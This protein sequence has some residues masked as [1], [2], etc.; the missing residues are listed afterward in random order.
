VITAVTT[1]LV[2]ALAGFVPLA[3]LSQ[4]TSIGRLF[5][6]VVVSIGVVVLRRT[7]PDLPRAFRAPLVPW[8]PIASVLACGWL[9]LNLPV[10][11]WVRFLIWMAVGLV[12][13]FVYGPATAG[14]ATPPRRWRRRRSRRS[15]SAVTQP[16]AQPGD[17]PGGRG[18]RSPG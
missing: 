11:T 7:R 16:G 10:E 14:C 6:F 2:A 18:H 15:T 12:L 13:Y 3:E 5:A 4:L 17:R 1:V 8:L 9:V